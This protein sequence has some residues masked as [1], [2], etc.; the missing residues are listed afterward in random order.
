[1]KKKLFPFI[2]GAAQVIIILLY[3]YQK[4]YGIQLSYQ[5]QKYEKQKSELFNQKQQLEQELYAVQDK[6]TIKKYALEHLKFKQIKLSHIK[7][8]EK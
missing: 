7:R 8:L 3:I 6:A 1:M 2:F 4:S 5:K